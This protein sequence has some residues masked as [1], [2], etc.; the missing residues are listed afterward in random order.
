MEGIVAKFS[1]IIPIY[2]VEQYLEHCLEQVVNQTF[3]D[4]EVICVNDGSTDNSLKILNDYAIKDTRFK[5]FSQ[6]NKGQG[7]ARNEALKIANGE[8]VIF[9]DPDDWIELNTL[10]EI[11]NAFQKSNSEVVE[12]NYQ[13]CNDNLEI[14]K[15]YNLAEKFRRKFHYN[16]D[17][18]T[19]YNWRNIKNV[20][21]SK[22]D[23]HVWSR[24]YSLKFL[25]K[26]NAMFSAEKIGEDHL[27]TDMVIL[28]AEKIHYLDKCLYNYRYR[29]GSS[30]D[31][32]SN[33]NFGIFRICKS[34]KE[35][36][37]NNNFYDELKD[38]FERYQAK[39]L[40]WHYKNLPNESTE[41]YLNMCKEILTP[42][43]YKKMLYKAKTK[44]SFWE[45][46]FSIKNERQKGVKYKLVT[47]FGIKF[48]IN[49]N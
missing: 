29:D 7:V 19:Y 31:K 43:E 36:L 1:I 32:I 49:K 48:T 14:I 38:D 15:K 27:F 34:V 17:I 13:D 41:N 12:F 33:D 11:V 20:C 40:C 22:I 24:A 9:I 5:V 26:I 28:N 25:R 42:K 30:V 23:F 44:N 18:I 10:E 47:I 3:K 2:N 46:I 6:E 16:L 45:T 37:V 8:Y 21:L 4:F 39:V 35:Y